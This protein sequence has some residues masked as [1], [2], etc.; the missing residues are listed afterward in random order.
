MKSSRK[1]AFYADLVFQIF[2]EVYEPAEDTFL[3]S[4]YLTQ[5]VRE[6]DTVLDMGT[7]CGMLAV[8]AAKKALKVVATDLNPHA[9]ECA[10]LNI[11]ANNVSGK[12]DVRQGDLFELIPKTEKFD[13]IVFNAPYLPSE[14]DEKKTWVGRAWAGGPTGRQ[15][16]DKFID[17]APQYLKENGR[18]LLA[19]S[20]LAKVEKTI[21]KFSRAGLETSI[22]AEKK[23]PFETIVIVQAK[24]FISRKQ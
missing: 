7:G 22:V 4:D 11:Q 1:Q 6:T 9:I 12:V 14:P 2:G 5:V 21:T 16:I 23:F 10:R 17:E 19:Q 24:A 3:M 18:I 20:T 13:L 15:I 8:I